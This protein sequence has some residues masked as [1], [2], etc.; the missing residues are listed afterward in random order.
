MKYS[1]LLTIAF[2]I[3]LTASSCSK[4]VIDEEESGNSGTTTPTEKTVKSVTLSFDDETVSMSQQPLTRAIVDDGKKYYGINIYEK[5]GNKYAKYAYGLF[6][7]TATV[8]ALMT[9]GK[10]YK[11]EVME[12]KN[13]EDTLYHEGTTFYAPMMRSDGKSTVLSN[14]FTY[15]SDVN[16]SGI[17]K[18]FTQTGKEESDT[19]WYPSAYRYYGTVTDFDPT[20][21]D[22][23]SIE[24]R[25]AFFG[26]H[27]IVTPPKYGTVEMGYLRNHSFSVSSN[28]TEYDNES[29]YSFNQIVPASADDY[30]ANIQF[31]YIWKSEGE[32]IKDEWTTI[33]V[34]RNTM[35]IVKIQFSGPTPIVESINEE[36]TPMD[37]LDYNLYIE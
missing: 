8:T 34:K 2:L 17:T 11:I 35:T 10:K 5:S 31:H 14:A 36:T 18:G 21:A 3:L 4:S 1:N 6:D 15:D 26:L 29:I 20:T 13:G 28:D 33:P 7:Q 32:T 19:T 25:R 37:S 23:I 27:F 30:S 24:V 22:N 12:F 16:L 9:E